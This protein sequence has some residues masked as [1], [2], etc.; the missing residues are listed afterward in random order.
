MRIP[1]PEQPWDLRTEIAEQKGATLTRTILSLTKATAKDTFWR[2]QNKNQTLQSCEQSV[3]KNDPRQA[4][5]I[6]SGL[7]NRIWD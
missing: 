7:I 5:T 3:W 6:K 2:Q 1:H 4:S